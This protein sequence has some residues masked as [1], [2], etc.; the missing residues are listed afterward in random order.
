MV[1]DT[2]APTIHNEVL[3]VMC[4]ICLL[5]QHV[6]KKM[7]PDSAAGN[8]GAH[9]QRRVKFMSREYRRIDDLTFERNRMQARYALEKCLVAMGKPST[10]A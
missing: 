2:H 5:R 9:F 4:T 1:Q 7:C 3:T 8:P 6:E 10:Y